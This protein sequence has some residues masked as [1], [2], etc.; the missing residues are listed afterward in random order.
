VERAPCRPAP[1]VLERQQHRPVVEVAAADV[2]V[3]IVERPFGSVQR[4]V[5]HQV[6]LGQEVVLRP[7]Q[8]R[9]LAPELGPQLA[10]L[11][12]PLERLVH[13]L[14]H[15]DLL[16]EVGRLHA[17]GIDRD[18]EDRIAQQRRIDQPLELVDRA[19]HRGLGGQD[20]L[21]LGRHARPRPG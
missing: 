11:G 2:A 14:V 18:E 19:Q 7:D 1:G 17:R 9:V 16:V 3:G 5:S 10:H 4:R 6:E 12:P 13:R 21:L 20:A 15:G 8:H